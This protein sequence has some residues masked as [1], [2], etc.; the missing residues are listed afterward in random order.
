M[1]RQEALL[2]LTPK[3]NWSYGKMPSS[4]SI[5]ELMK[6]VDA[7]HPSPSQRAERVYSILM[8]HAPELSLWDIACFSIEM[9][10]KVSLDPSFQ[11]VIGAPVK[12]LSRQI[13]SIHYFNSE[14]LF[15]A[16]TGAEGLGD[17]SDPATILSDRDSG[18]AART[19]E[20]G[21]T[22]KKASDPGVTAGSGAG[23]DNEDN[24]GHPPDR[25]EREV[26]GDAEGSKGG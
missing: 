11:P 7:L 15:G 1:V 21:D 2:R 19:P 5:K 20:E 13:Y 26:S 16:Q 4:D 8:H 3:K 23:T 24:K 10:G 17:R 25:T 18:K 14:E 12:E 6:E 9:L 22:S